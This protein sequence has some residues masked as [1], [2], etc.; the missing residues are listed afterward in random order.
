M[1]WRTVTSNSAY[2]V[3]DTGLVRRI[4]KSKCLSI[5]KSKHRHTTYCRVTLFNNNIRQYKQVHR[6]VGE[7]FIP[8]PTNLPQIDH[9]DGNGEN[10]TVSNL[11]WVTAS[12]NIK[13]SFIT[14]TNKVLICSEGGKAGAKRQQEKAVEKYSRMLGDRFVEYHIGGSLIKDGAVTYKCSCG[15]VRT[16]SIMWKELRNHQGKC[17][18]CTDTTNRS[19]KSLI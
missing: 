3:S 7:A 9:L 11:N 15:A 18:V 2:E 1:E 10:N 8:N 12:E 5:S 6:L 4:G 14:N 13:R 19:N 17:P 16:A